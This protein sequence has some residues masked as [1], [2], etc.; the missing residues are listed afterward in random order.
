MIDK[1]K[2]K[3]TETTVLTKEV[4]S[5]KLSQNAERKSN[6]IQFLVDKN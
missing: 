6:K 1:K 5:D 3:V 4:Q 2:E